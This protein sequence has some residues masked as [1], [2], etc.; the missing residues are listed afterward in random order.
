MVDNK[1]CL[2]EFIIKCIDYKGAKNVC[3]LID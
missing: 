1:K 3:S 2:N